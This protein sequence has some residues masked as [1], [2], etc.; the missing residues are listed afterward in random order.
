MCVMFSCQN[1]P[2]ND[3]LM[4]FF[5]C[6]LK[7]FLLGEDKIDS[8]S[9]AVRK[10]WYFIFACA[11]FFVSIRKHWSFLLA[12]KDSI[13][14]SIGLQ[15]HPIHPETEVLWP[16]SVSLYSKRYTLH[17]VPFFFFACYSTPCLYSCSCCSLV[18]ALNRRG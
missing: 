9:I 2:F 15:L 7:I 11:L 10:H 16:F 6:C 12:W 18:V 3:N 5:T 8:L 17:F 14:P 4:C 13:H 1:W